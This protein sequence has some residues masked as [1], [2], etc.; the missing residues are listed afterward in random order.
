[1]RQSELIGLHWKDIDFHFREVKITRSMWRNKEFN[2]KTRASRS[3]DAYLP[4]LAI[5]LN[6]IAV[7]YLARGRMLKAQRLM[8]R[9]LRSGAGSPQ[10]GRINSTLKFT[11][12]NR[13]LNS[14]PLAEGVSWTAARHW[15]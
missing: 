13:L 4:D 15:E 10:L 8:G 5:T 14:S 12:I 3:P 7:L 2:C 11:K 6:N 9:L 1:M